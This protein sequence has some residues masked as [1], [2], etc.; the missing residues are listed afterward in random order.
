MMKFKSILS[1]IVLLCL[2]VSG[3]AENSTT[4]TTTFYYCNERLEYG[5]NTS[6]I[7]SEQ[8][9]EVIDPLAYEALLNLYLSGPKSSNL[10]SPFP[11]GTQLISIDIEQGRACLVLSNEFS[12]LTGVD[13]SLACACLALTASDITQC[14]KVEISVE[15]A[16]LDNRQKILMDTSTLQMSD[17]DQ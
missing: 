3:C 13:L 15:N 16:L 14:V 2:F 17:S 1:I 4:G 5:F 10:K 8:R 11:S 12:E 7:D 6:A 9:K